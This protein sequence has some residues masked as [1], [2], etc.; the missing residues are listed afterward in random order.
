[1]V[2]AADHMHAHIAAAAEPPPMP[3]PAPVHSALI[4]SAAHTIPLPP[5]QDQ[6]AQG[7]GVKTG[8]AA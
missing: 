5:L 3:L 1:M 4:N 6:G 7:S 8:A 2:G